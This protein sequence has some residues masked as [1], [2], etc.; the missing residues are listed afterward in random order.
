MPNLTVLADTEANRALLNPTFRE[1][2]TVISGIKEK[3]GID[4]FNYDSV[5]AF[6]NAWLASLETKVLVCIKH[7]LGSDGAPT[8]ALDAVLEARMTDATIFTENT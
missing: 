2:L 4:Y 3:H 8:E 5:E 6:E 1:M 7:I